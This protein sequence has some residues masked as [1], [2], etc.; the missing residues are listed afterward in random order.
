MFSSAVQE[1]PVGDGVRAVLHRLGLAV[2]RR[3]RAAVEVVAADDDR[4]GDLAARARASLNASAGLRA[5][6]VAEPADARGQALEL[7]RARRAMR[8]QR[9]SARS[10][11]EEL[12]HDPVG[13]G[14]VLRIA[15]E[16]DPAERA[17][18]LAE[19]RPDV[20]RARSPRMPKASREAGLL[21]DGR[22]GCCRSRRCPRRGAAARAS[23]CSARPSCAATR[24]RSAFG[25]LRAQR[26]RRVVASSRSARSRRADRARCVW[27]VRTSGSTPR[28]ISALE[29]STAL[30]RTPIDC[31][32]PVAL[33]LERLVDRR[34]EVVDHHVEVARVE[35]LLDARA[36][37]V[38][39]R[40]TSPSFIVAASGCAPP[41]PPRPPVTTR[42]SFE[43]AA[44]V[45]RAPTRR[46]SRR[47]PA[48]FPACRCR[49][50]SRP[51]SGRT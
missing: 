51:S 5:L 36:I 41:M 1:R 44:E 43:R 31:A 39:R 6:A 11:R 18:A 24:A 19:E 45:L 13:D 10:S 46:T 14:D 7:R 37:D 33:P 3:D 16:R 2:G 12:E 26:E 28:A 49:S 29:R 23:P 4:R 22:A 17:L 50:T 8:I 21:R 25:S 48:G 15:G 27:S 35:A 40:G 20:L 34:V 42:R 38:R 9:A 30:P 32:T 47:C